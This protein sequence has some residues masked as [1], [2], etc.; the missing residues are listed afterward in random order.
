[1][2]IFV[3]ENIPQGR[4]AF[5]PFGEVETFAGRSLEARRLAGA[6]ALIVR[7]V[8]K[9]DARLLDGSGVRFV[10]TATIGED[11]VDRAYLK[12][13]SIGFASAPGCNA[14]S[15]AEYF[16]ASLAFL[17]QSRGL[18]LSGK[19]LGIIGF[20][21]VGRAVEKKA[22]ALG[23]RVLRND[24]PLAEKTAAEAGPASEE[25][26]APGHS[27]SHGGLPPLSFV[28]LDAVLAESDLLT[29]HVP[30]TRGGAHPTFRLAGR[31]FFAK[32]KPGAVLLNTCRG[33]VVDE[34]ALAEALKKGRLSGLVS[35]VFQ[36]EPRPDSSLW[37]GADLI[38]P[39][40]A[41]YSIAGKLNGTVAMHRAFAAYFGAAPAWTP[42]WPRPEN[43][44][45]PFAE[46][47]DNG[48]FLSRCILHAYPIPRDD[49]ALRAALRSPDP[50]GAFDGLR[51]SYP[52]RHEFA[53]FSVE[54]LPKSRSALRET[55]RGLGFR[56]S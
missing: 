13:R 26:S 17:Q 27:A 20:G 56:V 51:K 6:D 46:G 25:Q 28:S 36:G 9:V 8:T 3:D 53:D 4:E 31:D 30:L 14:N 55:L 48:A 16:V 49:A 12:A 21:H 33:E 1:M 35:D 34:T 42:E 2:R 22:R 52:V 29:L 32:T 5:A 18:E 23:L 15:V 39:H 50:G 11:H 7:S 43:P 54:G 38:T 47:L 10:G 44:A 19:T 24:P 40:I 41:G 37:T 45:I